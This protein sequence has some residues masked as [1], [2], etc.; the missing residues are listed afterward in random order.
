MPDPLRITHAISGLDPKIGG[1]PAALE[2]LTQSQLKLGLEVTVVSTYRTGDDPSLAERMRGRGIDVRLIGPCRTPLQIAR[3]ISPELR[4]LAQASDVFHIHALYE[5]IQYA[6]TRA[7]QKF[8]VPY[9]IRPCGMLAPWCLAQN[10]SRKKIYLAW[11][12]RKM[13]DRA[14]AI[15]FT[16]ED[17]RQRTAPLGFTAPTIVEPN[18]IHVQNF[19]RA[20]GPEHNLRHAYPQLGDSPII[21]FYGRL[22]PKKGADVLIHAFAKLLGRWPAGQPSPK[23]VM[24]GPDAD[25]YQ[26]QL[27]RT[28]AE[29]GCQSHIVFTGM[30]SGDA[31]VGALQSADLFALTS[32]Q[33]NFGI[34]VV[35]AL[36]AGTP[37]VISDQVNIYDRVVAGGVGEA[38]P[39]DAEQASNALWRW[40]TDD[41]KRQAAATKA[42]SWAQATYG[43]DGI[44]R[45]WAENHYPAL[46][47]DSITTAD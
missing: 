33:E 32:H 16:T 19:A 20:V 39:V 31:A 37:V 23:L 29:A 28:A 4:T 46:L 6:A 30:L 21:V 26:Q 11:R 13:L 15:H 35:E 36:A 2:G 44:A 25:G 40:L 41:E 34:A 1:P 12:L 5:Q 42:A 24:V 43:W 9:A 18:G 27:E 17:E 10:A 3:G 22:H 45:H 14:G 38:V 7:A 47:S 8:R